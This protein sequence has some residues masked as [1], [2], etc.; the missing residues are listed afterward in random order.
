MTSETH[1]K[2][3][4]GEGKNIKN[5]LIDAIIYSEKEWAQKEKKEWEKAEKI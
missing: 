4:V 3:T 1:V 5:Q 2:V